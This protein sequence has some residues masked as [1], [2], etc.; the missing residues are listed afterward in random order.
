LFPP[1]PYLSRD[2]LRRSGELFLEQY[3]RSDE[4]PVPIEEIIEF[5]LGLEIRPIPGLRHRF[6]IDGSLTVD[7]QTIVVDAELLTRW[8]RRYRFTL[9]HEIGHRIL[10]PQQVQALGGGTREEWKTAVRGIPPREYSW[11]EF[12]ASEFAG[13]VLVPRHPLLERYQEAARR[14]ER[15]GIDLA[16][17][18]DWS[19]SQ[20]AGWIADHF[21][22]STDVVEV[23]LKNEGI[24]S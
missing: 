13:H 24:T 19:M 11:M 10:H 8:P 3:H 18:R 16:E 6:G 20:V 21:D 7:L 2:E 1:V 4:I 9:A 12:Q 17:L 15:G 5:D 22:V 14:A 23:R